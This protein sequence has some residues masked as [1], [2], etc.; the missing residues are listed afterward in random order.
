MKAATTPFG[1]PSSPSSAGEPP[2]VV[3]PSNAPRDV[4]GLASSAGR[5]AHHLEVPFGHRPGRD[6]SCLRVDAVAR[7]GSG[8]S[9]SRRPLLVC[10][11]RRLGTDRDARTSRIANGEP[12]PPPPTDA[13]RNRAKSRSTVVDRAPGSS[14][15][16]GSP[17]DVLLRG[18]DLAELVGGGEGGSTGEK[19]GEEGRERDGSRAGRAAAGRRRRARRGW[20]SSRSSP[21]AAASGPPWA[22]TQSQLKSPQMNGSSP[23][24][25]P[26][27]RRRRRRGARS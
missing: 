5:P 9:T 17:G 2:A 1:P 8:A 16:G 20:P 6:H 22:C 4:R 10:D 14:P 25:P 13:G 23:V 18:C 27:R 15:S 21:L 11:E 26:R 24:R 7:P 19:D 3:I 12:E